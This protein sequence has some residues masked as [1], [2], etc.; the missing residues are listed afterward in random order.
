MFFLTSFYS[1]LI[2]SSIM[3]YGFIFNKIFNF[4]VSNHTHY[5][6]L[7]SL[8]IIF[9]SLAV[10]FFLPL[11]IFITSTI[12]YFTSVLGLIFII[13][14]LKKF[15]ELTF[16]IIFTTLITYKSSPYDDYYLYQLPYIEILKNFKIVF[17]LSNIEWRFG[18]TSIIQNI[19]AFLSNGLMKNDSYIFFAPLLVSIVLLEIYNIFLTSKNKLTIVLCSIFIS[20]YLIHA[21]RYGALGN[22]YPSHALAFLSFIFFLNIF[23]KDNKE[24]INFL[25]Y[26]LISVIII[27]FFS[28]LSFIFLF[29]LIFFV[30]FKKY[31]FIKI[32]KSFII[33]S[34]I[35]LS[36][37]FVKNIINS[38]CFI[39][40]IYSTCIDSKWSPNEYSEYS[41]KYVA[42]L[43][44]VAAKDYQN[45]GL[46]NTNANF[47]KN[48][49]KENFDIYK[50]LNS[51][52][53]HVLDLIA[54]YSWYNQIQ[55]WLPAYL[56]NHFKQKILKEL[57]L[58]LLVILIFNY[59]FFIYFKNKFIKFSYKKLFSFEIIS[60]FSLNLIFI[61][62]W[63]LNFPLLRYGISFLLILISIP[64]Y[65]QINYFEVDIKKIKKYYLYFFAILMIYSLV[66]SVNRYI[67]FNETTNTTA[68]IVPLIIYPS[69][70]KNINGVKFSIANSVCGL[71][72]SPCIYSGNWKNFSNEFHV[73]LFKNYLF[74]T[75]KK[76]SLMNN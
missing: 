33:F 54:H 20:F 27:C 71:N 51:E 52:E 50:N 29:I 3:F 64:V 6:I 68:N 16:I 62:F 4:K 28:K 43:S 74:I 76:Y 13:F 15:K 66:Y 37:F 53:K 49:I 1:L 67:F 22:D 30:L 63:F 61:I 10:N 47:K 72:E 31:K 69:T 25:F 2:F 38:S 9:F 56:K 55:I 7:G 5:F 12:F 11:N 46:F 17:G 26:L 24:K 8:A 41:S 40:P 32:N 58:H 60:L 73:D 21:N 44:K 48:F 39:F 35:L 18:H 59:V 19:S 14:K 45:S 70:S 75:N 42:A 57:L 23:S 65:L 36:F 34:V